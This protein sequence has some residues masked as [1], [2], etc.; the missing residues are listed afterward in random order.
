V[1]HPTTF[2]QIIY[3]EPS[4][5]RT[6]EPRGLAGRTTDASLD[7]NNQNVTRITLHWNRVLLRSFARHLA[8]NL[9]RPAHTS[10]PRTSAATNVMAAIVTVQV[11]AAF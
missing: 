4:L 7:L 5:L 10:V 1:D 6:V 2:D 8:A 9:N 11:R 3:F